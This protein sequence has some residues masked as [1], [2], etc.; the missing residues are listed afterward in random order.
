M[1]NDYFSVV[2]SVPLKICFSYGT[3]L[4]PQIIIIKIAKSIRLSSLL[5]IYFDFRLIFHDVFQK[6]SAYYLL[7]LSLISRSPVYRITFIMLTIRFHVAHCYKVIYKHSVYSNYIVI[8]P[9]I[10]MVLS[11]NILN[12]HQEIGRCCHT[13]PSLFLLSFTFGSIRVYF[14]L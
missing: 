12:K 13:P 5:V 10:S 1:P 2:F 3:H 8:L 4:L 6:S 11:I 14:V 7:H 9:H